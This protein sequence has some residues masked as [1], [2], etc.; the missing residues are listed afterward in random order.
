MSFK[1]LIIFTKAYTQNLMKK[2]SIF[3]EIILKSPDYFTK[4]SFPLKMSY[5]SLVIFAKASEFLLKPP[6]L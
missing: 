5:K 1:R 6:F 3:L 2:T 4:A